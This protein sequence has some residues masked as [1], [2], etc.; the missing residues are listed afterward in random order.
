MRRKRNHHN[1]ARERACL[2]QSR[3]IMRLSATGVVRVDDGGGMRLGSSGRVCAGR[4]RSEG[5]ILTGLESSCLR[6]RRRRC[7]RRD[8]EEEAS[9]GEGSRS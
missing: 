3:T 1:I 4:Q 9:R 6:R 8:K 2:L 7:G 5:L